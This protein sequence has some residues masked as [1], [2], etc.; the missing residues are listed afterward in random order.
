MAAGLNITASHN[1]KEYNGYKVY[2]S[3]G[4]TL[5]PQKA[6]AIAKQMEAIDAFTGFKTCD[7]DEAVKSGRIEILGEETDELFMEQV[8]K[9]A[10]D[11]QAVADVADEF[12]I[13]YTPF[14]GCGY[15]LVPQR[16][17]AGE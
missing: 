16:R 8:L 7:Y 12:K 17:T 15:K 9:M 11:K 5:P 6:E 14:H 2:W 4:A 1:P 13:V 3:D 10:I